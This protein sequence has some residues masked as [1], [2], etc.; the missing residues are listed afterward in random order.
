MLIL[1]FIVWFYPISLRMLKFSWPHS[2]LCLLIYCLFASIGHAD[3]M[4]STATSNFGHILYLPSIS[5]CSIFVTWYF[6]VMADVVLLL[7]HFV[8]PFRYPHDSHR[9]MFSSLMSWL[10]VLLIYWPCIICFPIFSCKDSSNLAFVCGMPFF[11]VRLFTY[12]WFNSSATFASVLS[13]EFILSWSLI[14][15]LKYLQIVFFMFCVQIF[16][17]IAYLCFICLL[18]L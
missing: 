3:V 16:C 11:V 12:N 1:L 15:L 9:I 10:S 17:S 2:L 6:V 4:C 18:D 7:F 8:S 13:V 5:V 14:W